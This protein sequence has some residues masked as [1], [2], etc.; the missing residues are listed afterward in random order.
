MVVRT[1]NRRG[2][3]FPG[4]GSVSRAQSDRDEKRV[5]AGLSSNMYTQKL[6]LAK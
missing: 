2:F 4:I 5:F 6:F 3:S 1:R